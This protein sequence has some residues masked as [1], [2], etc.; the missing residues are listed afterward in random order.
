VNL[1]ADA[2][3]HR[4]ATRV[5]DVG[6]GASG[7]S[8][9]PPIWPTAVW[10]SDGLEAAHRGATTIRSGQFYGRYGNPT[11]RAFEEAVAELERAGL[12]DIDAMAFGSGMGAV[13]STILALCSAGSHVVAARQIY[14]GTLAFLQGPAARFG[15][16]T[17]FV[18][19]TQPGALEAA[20][21]PGRTV[22]VIAETPSNPRLELVD[23]DEVGS[24]V[25][26]FTMIDSTFATPLGQNPLAH[27]VDLVLH[28]ATK[29]ISGHNDVTLGVVA[30]EADLIAEL[31]S[32]GVL[33]GATASPY[34]AHNALRG[35]RTLHVRLAQQTGT[36]QR[37]AEF[38][39]EHPAVSAVHYPGLAG[40]PQHDLAKR[41]MREF[42][43][44][45]AF[46]LR[47]GRDAV[48]SMFT[49]MGVA[50]CAT[51]LGGTETL[52]THPATTTAVSLTPA[53]KDEAGVSEGLVR[54][55]VGLE[56]PHD[57]IDDLSQ[58]LR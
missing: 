14:S 33:H 1:M 45:L 16:E 27:G 25:G 7:T 6:R 50:R 13:T 44:M 57:L 24:I 47:G 32:Y 46:E 53:E 40:H 18:D 39:A 11:V 34:D 10:Q 35:I 43:S 41:Q 12:P 31:W 2:P 36:A 15:I 52:M 17:T 20:V 42:G 3:E 56:D 21:Q 38:L 29:G 37:L 8:L 54:V 9:N 5:I 28:S 19:S 48:A 49:R 55:S 51:S 26:P 23:L 30:G 22:L 58:A 4:P